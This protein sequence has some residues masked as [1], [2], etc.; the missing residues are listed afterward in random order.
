MQIPVLS[1]L[2]LRLKSGN[3]DSEARA[4]GRPEQSQTATKTATD[5]VSGAGTAASKCQA[6]RATDGTQTG[7]NRAG[8]WSQ[9]GGHVNENVA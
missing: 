1:A 8:G 2:H 4:R 6:D 9:A 3:A 7:Q 5:R